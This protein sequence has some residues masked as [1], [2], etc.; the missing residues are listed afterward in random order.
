[1]M[2]KEE[3]RGEEKEYMEE[4]L[5]R[6]KSNLERSEPGYAWS[7][8]RHDVRPIL[9]YVIRR[10]RRAW[11]ITRDRLVARRARRSS[12]ETARAPLRFSTPIPAGTIAVVIHSAQN[13]L[14][15]E[16]I[17]LLFLAVGLQGHRRR[18]GSQSGRY[19]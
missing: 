13:L 2:R 1:M 16:D 9:K 8:E 18:L 15:R 5:K 4:L 3:A 12:S 6:Y 10:D 7:I 11:P 19:P 17:Q 14:W